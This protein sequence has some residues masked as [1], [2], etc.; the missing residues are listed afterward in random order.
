[1][2]IDYGNHNLTT[3]GEVVGSGV[4]SSDPTLVA[5]STALTNVVVITQANY[6]NLGSYSDTT[7]YVITD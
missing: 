3:S 6:D 2:P 1:M 7:L 5:N 4:V